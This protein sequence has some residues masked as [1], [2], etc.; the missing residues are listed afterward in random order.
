MYLN[1]SARV[2]LLALQCML[3]RTRLEARIP[4]APDIQLFV[5]VKRMASMP[6]RT[7]SFQ[8]MQGAL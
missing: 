8:N 5:L 4:E 3:R 1:D 6:S 7:S 2:A